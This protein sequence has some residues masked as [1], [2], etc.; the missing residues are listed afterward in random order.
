MDLYPFIGHPVSSDMAIEY[1]DYCTLV[2]SY[3]CPVRFHHYLGT[4]SQI[5]RIVLGAWSKSFPDYN[6]N[7]FSIFNK[8]NKSTYLIASI[9][10]N[11]VSIFSRRSWRNLGYFFLTYNLLLIGGRGGINVA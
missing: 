3:V 10:I 11:F 2:G 8:N 6:P 7:Y 9:D 1:N 4:K 5:S